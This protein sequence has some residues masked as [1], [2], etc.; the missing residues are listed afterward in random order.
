MKIIKVVDT[1]AYEEGPDDKWYP[2]PGSGEMNICSRC[3]KGHEIHVTVEDDAGKNAVVGLGC[4]KK[5]NLISETAH[6]SLTS[7]SMT[8]AKNKA[9]LEKLLRNQKIQ[10]DIKNQV[11]NIPLPDIEKGL[12]ARSN[13]P[14]ENFGKV[15]AEIWKMGDSVVYLP[16]FMSRTE[17]NFEERKRCLIQSWRSKRFEEIAK[18]IPGFKGVQDYLIEDTKKRIQKVEKK[19]KLIMEIN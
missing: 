8:L 6:K 12:E 19:I 4:A 15:Y 5:E 18:T 11:D 17:E 2:I 3:G 1:R 14:G 7:A 16:Q 9:Q 13:V 10:E